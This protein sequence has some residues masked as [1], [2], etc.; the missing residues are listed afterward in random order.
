MY[1]SP[2]MVPQDADHDMYLVLLDTFGVWV[3]RAWRETDD[4][5]GTYREMLIRDLLHEVYSCP[6]RIVAF[7]TAEGWSRNITTEI[8]AELKQRRNEGE[9]IPASV[10]YLLELAGSVARQSGW[11]HSDN[12][13]SHFGGR[14]ERMI[15]AARR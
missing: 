5:G 4:D 13:H 9:N 2:S 10:Q 8:A 12:Q 3:G 11:E 6:V 1:R 15:V 14:G 7:N